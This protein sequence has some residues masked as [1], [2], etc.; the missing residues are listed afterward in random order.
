MIFICQSPVTAMALTT[1]TQTTA[2]ST[3]APTDQIKIDP[4]ELGQFMDK[5]VNERMEKFNVPGYTVSVVQ[6][7][8]VIFAKGYGYADANKTVQVDSE[9][10]LFRI[11]SVSKLFVW[12]AVMQ[13]VERNQ[14]DLNANVNKYLGD[15]QIPDTFPQ[16]ITLA[17]LLTHTAGFDKRD[18]GELSPVSDQS[19]DLTDYIQNDLPKRILPPGEFHVYSNYGTNLAAYIVEQ[20]SGMSFERYVAENI[21]NPLGMSRSTFQQ[22]LP[23]VLAADMA[24]GYYWQT[25]FPIGKPGDFEILP[26]SGAL[27]TTAVDMAK[28]MLAH[29][30]KPAE[31]SLPILRPDTLEL[32]HTTQFRFD[33]RLPGYTYGFFET[34]RNGQR[35]IGHTGGTTQF[36]GSVMLIPEH[37]IGLFEAYTGGTKG[38]GFLKEDFVDHY[39][40]TD[41]GAPPQ[42]A[43]MVSPDLGSFQGT[44]RTTL[45]SRTTFEKTIQLLNSGDKVTTNADGTLNFQGSRWIRIDPLTFQKEGSAELLVFQT[46]DGLLGGKITYLFIGNEALEKLSWFESMPFQFAALAVGLLVFIINII[47]LPVSAL[48]RRKR[49]EKYSLSQRVGRW[50]I[51]LACAANL[52]FIISF[53]LLIFKAVYFGFPGLQKMIFLLP[54]LSIVFCAV[55]LVLM[56][57]NQHGINA[58]PRWTRSTKAA[59]LVVAAAS[60]GFAWWLS[61][62]NLL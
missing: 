2:S 18:Q 28:F 34:H 8:K 39:F 5:L 32:M 16:P 10:T 4:I 3:L 12:T 26:P 42:P 62:W 13:L 21:L 33:P 9:Q 58:S 51:W 6:D 54:I 44:Y 55:S 11:G 53:A 25:G 14:V 29:L 1:T 17:N 24:E 35:L 19:F 45:V 37:N 49:A 41:E 15:F 22:P 36:S 57:I 50:L 52:M 43:A 48:I 46:Q 27:S 23:P 47:A 59:I 40:R 38:C 56:E 31:G 30:N 60:T 61:Y 20:V 7:G